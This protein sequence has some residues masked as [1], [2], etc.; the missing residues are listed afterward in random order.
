MRLSLSVFIKK[1]QEF[2]LLTFLMSAMLVYP[3][4]E[5]ERAFNRVSFRIFPIKGSIGSS[6][7]VDAKDIEGVSLA[8]GFSFKTIKVGNYTAIWVETTR[9]ACL[10][11]RRFLTNG[12]MPTNI[13][14][15]LGTSNDFL[16]KE[17]IYNSSSYIVVGIVSDN[18][19][20]V[21][22][23]SSAKVFF[24]HFK[25]KV[26]SYHLINIFVDPLSNF[27]EIKYR[28]KLVFGDD[29]AILTLIHYDVIQ[30]NLLLNIV[31]SM[32]STIVVVFLYLHLSKQEHAILFAS[33]WRFKNIFFINFF[34]LV[35]ILLVSFFLTYFELYLI[36]WFYLRL[37]L[38]ISLTLFSPLLAIILDSFFLYL[39]LKY[40][41]IKNYY[42]VLVE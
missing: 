9:D 25:N 15:L 35:L 24:I 39:Y 42:Q 10:I 1:W 22:F 17:I 38:F 31:L 19:A 29:V 40:V 34:R 8:V 21:L 33:G 5:Y 14:E 12:R 13:N 18:F 30:I 3:L 28:L 4:Y 27:K 36:T 20:K 23:G 37:N 6:K 32:I 41:L 16:S 2:I 11:L 26:S 7:L